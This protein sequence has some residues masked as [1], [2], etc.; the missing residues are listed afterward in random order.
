[1]K[2]ITF[3][4]E[5]RLIEQARETARARNTTLNEEFRQWLEDYAGRARFGEE[6]DAVMKRLSYVR[7]GRKF[8]RDEM[9]ER[10]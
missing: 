1:M 8:T 9:N 5:E 7:A 10:G 6:F 2:N 4:A 3:S